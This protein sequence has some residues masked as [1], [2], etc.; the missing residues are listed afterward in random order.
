MS[1]NVKLRTLLGAIVVPPIVLLGLIA[2]YG[3]LIYLRGVPSAAEI[4]QDILLLSLVAIAGMILSAAMVLVIGRR[5]M[6]PITEV[7]EAAT[8]LAEVRLPM[9]IESLSTPG[10]SA[11]EFAPL[12]IHGK[13]ELAELGDALNMLQDRAVAVAAEQQRVVKEGISELVI[14]LARRNQSL[15]DRQIDTIDELES[16][17]ENPDRLEKLFR[18]D[19][20]ATR[21]RRNAESLLVLAGAEPSRRR[22]GPVVLSDVVRVAM[23]EIEDYQHVTL[24]S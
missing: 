2:G 17:E 21:M 10:A 8:E 4:R 18:L 11:P 16:N 6:Q 13:T 5:V 7:S 23:S 19:H 14:N 22:G 12:Q 24:A 1:R 20:L 3:A 9:L 15:L